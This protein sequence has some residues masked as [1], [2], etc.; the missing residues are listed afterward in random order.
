MYH[1]GATDS[2][3]PCAMMLN[4][5]KT[6]KNYLNQVRT[7]RDLSLKLVFFDGEEAFVKWGPNDSIYGA[8][9]LAELYHNSLRSVST[10]ETVSDLDKIDLLV[11]LDLI[12]HKGTKFY[13][14]FDNTQNW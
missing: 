12:G 8:K 9:H 1:L 6:M 3:V 5:A 13:S 10:G 14:C 4:L 2:A 7:N 11:L